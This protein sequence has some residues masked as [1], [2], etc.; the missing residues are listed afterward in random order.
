MDMIELLQRLGYYPRFCVWELTLACELRCLHCGSHAGAQRESELSI[1]ECRRL[2]DELA[3]LGCEKV[4]LGGGEPTLHPAWH[5]IGRRLSDQGVRVNV[6]SNGWA[7]S[8]DRLEQAR[9]AKL[10]NVAFSLDGLEQAHDA[11]RRKD[12]FRRVVAA[13]DL[14]VAEEATAKRLGEDFRPGLLQ[15]FEANGVVVSDVLHSRV[16]RWRGGVGFDILCFRVSP[17]VSH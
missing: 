8:Q 11:V 17:V 7:W 13:I 15:L 5:E 12:S 6:I 10:T 16:E 1:E 2:A 4:T 3:A 14:C 9:Y